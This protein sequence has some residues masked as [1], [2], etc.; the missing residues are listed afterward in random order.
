VLLL[1][2]S[3]AVRWR[4]GD[5]MTRRISRQSSQADA[6]V[7]YDALLCEVLKQAVDDYRRLSRS[8]VIRNGQIGR[9]R[10]C[11]TGFYASVS[12][13]KELINFFR[14]NELERF[15]DAACLRVDANALRG[16]LGVT[17]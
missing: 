9:L 8:G 7:G 5:A 4:T 3:P 6:P 15:I 13:V 10:K 16:A 2:V 1:D 12:P 11:G 14:T 17:Q